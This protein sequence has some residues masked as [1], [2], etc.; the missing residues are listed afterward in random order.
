MRNHRLR[1]PSSSAIRV[2]VFS[3]L[4]LVAAACLLGAFARG[5]SRRPRRREPVLHLTN[6]G[7]VPG[8]LAR[9]GH[10]R[11]RSAGRRRRSSPRSSSTST[12][13]TPSTSAPRRTCPGRSATTASSW[14]EATSSS[15]RCR[16]GRRRGRCS[17][18]RGSAGSTSSAP[19]STGST[20]GATAP[21]WST[22]GPNGLT[23]WTDSSAG[24]VKGWREESGELVD[25]PGGGGDPRRPRP[26][27]PG[28]HRVRD[29]LEEQ[30]R[31]RPRARRERRRAGRRSGPSASRSGKTTWS[32]TAR[33]SS[34]ADVASVGAV[35][36]GPGR[37]HLQAYLD[38]ERGRIL[39]FSPERRSRWPT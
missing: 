21:T 30:A 2:P 15:A 36:P 6:G 33:P 4:S 28:G 20:A 5:R 24:D 26:P 11:R 38:Q 17:T 12:R 9:L 35:D 29:L 7:F 31:L 32:S 1:R 19:A 16:P 25:R 18:S 14:P 23:G 37:A 22:S 34:E 39:V 27:R 8:T 13:S 10:G 3:R